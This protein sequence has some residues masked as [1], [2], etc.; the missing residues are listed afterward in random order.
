MEL[1]NIIDI[2]MR[3]R[4]ILP[5]SVINDRKESPVAEQEDRQ[6]A[7]ELQR[8]AEELRKRAFE[9]E[10][11]R[12][13]DEAEKRAREMAQE[14][15]TEDQ[16]LHK[17]KLQDAEFQKLRAEQLR[18]AQE[19]EVQRV[20]DLDRQKRQEARLREE[21]EQKRREED[22][23]R[24]ADEKRMQEEISRQKAEDEKMRRE[25]E[26][27]R[28]EETDKKRVELDTLRREQER[29]RREVEK[30]ERVESLLKSAK[31]FYINGDYEHA[32]IEVAKALVNDPSHIEALALEQK[33]KETQGK[34]KDKVVEEKPVE[35]KA[36]VKPSTVRAP[37]VEKSPTVKLLIY[38]IIIGIL[39]LA[40]IIV[41]QVKKKIFTTPVG[42][43]VLPLSSPTN[44]LEDKILGAALSSEIID[45]F[46][47]SRSYMPLGYSSSYRISHIS[48]APEAAA[49]RLGY[50][51][52]L[53]GSIGHSD[54][55]IFIR[56]R[57]I[58]SSG[59]LVWQDDYSKPAEILHEI[60]D[61]IYHQITETLHPETGEPAGPTSTAHRIIN[62]DAYLMYL[63][64]LEMLPR[65]TSESSL[66]A[67]QLFN[68][69]IQQ[70]GLFPEPRT[71]AASVM[72]TRFENGWDTSSASL[73]QA[74]FMAETSL[75]I[76]PS[77]GP[78][79]CVLGD[80]AM[81]GHAYGRALQLFDTAINYMPRSSRVY[82]DR[83]K[84]YFRWEKYNEVVD[85]M[86]H[87]YEL[88]PRNIEILETF[89][90]LHQLM[91]TPRQGMGYH[92]AVLSIV[93]DSTAY[94][95]GPIA[96]ILL[97]DAG[98]LLSYSDR[99]INAC[100]HH[101]R[102]DSTDYTTMYRLARVYQVTGNSMAA[103]SIFNKIETLLRKKIQQN[104]RDGKA[105][106]Y[107]GLTLT[108][109][110]RFP[111]ATG[112]AEHAVETDGRNTEVEYTVAQM[113]SLQMYS[114]KN[115]TI[116]EKKKSMAIQ[117]LKGALGL[118][119]RLD[120]LT[121]ADFFNMY[122]H[123]ELSSAIHQPIPSH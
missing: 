62:Q 31:N 50:A 86:A 80:I 117:T 14:R 41:I 99:V 94:L 95:I 13:D 6:K 107:L 60:P 115:K 11:R 47:R 120:E 1:T 104:P 70:D 42:L 114:S 84:L 34:T 108:R 63:R 121:N 97:M 81:L 92:E 38:A 109:L 65:L 20:L 78:A 2:G 59:N 5:V 43:A 22:E 91:G 36:Q 54:N 52:V 46:E 100:Q 26:Q 77:N 116:D 33:I 118:G 111:E 39:V 103:I 85:A 74:Q 83:A 76:D 67:L 3:F 24:R 56:L 53:E 40:T 28:K 15:L 48:N 21:M 12:I 45:E 16:N 18:Q 82:F 69:A 105:F 32:A 101:L 57:M 4:Y 79:Y 102:A 23:K 119:Y 87:A 55:K 9:E 89:G 113:Y 123:G 90:F 58:D 30:Q 72:I 37:K 68:Q 71:A 29:L 7:E 35:N 27:R 110:G 10:T 75:K 73:K 25:E 17:Q 98:L 112:F 66:N 93:D 49:F 51:Y 44:I 8:K 64:G 122:E 96:D 61:D 88:D 19:D 106:A